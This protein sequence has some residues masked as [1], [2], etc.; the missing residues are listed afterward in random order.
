MM[1][2]R[3]VLIIIMMMID[4]D[5]NV[6]SYLLRRVDDSIWACIEGIRSLHAS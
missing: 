3:I 4:H 1:M 2:L 5:I 6:T